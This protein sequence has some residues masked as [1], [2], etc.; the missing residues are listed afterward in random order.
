MTTYYLTSYQRFV[1]DE[2]NA[3]A[4]VHLLAACRELGDATVTLGAY[5]Y[6]HPNGLTAVE[7]TVVLRTKG[8]V[9]E[10]VWAL[11]HEAGQESVLRVDARGPALMLDTGPVALCDGRAFTSLRDALNYNG[12]RGATLD[13]LTG[14]WVAY[15]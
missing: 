15:V 14:K 13:P 8:E 10:A 5:R 2:T 9:D 11:A 3:E 6:T 4:F 1:R 7:P 12:G